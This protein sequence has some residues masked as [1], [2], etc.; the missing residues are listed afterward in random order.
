MKDLLKDAGHLLR[1]VLVFAVGFIL[2]LTVRAIAVPHSFGQYGHY[3]GD[4]LSEI[5][6]RPINFAGR[7][8]CV[9]CHQEVDDLKKTGKHAGVG[10]ESCHGALAAHAEDP[11]KLVPKLPD[12]AV[13]CVKCHEANSAKPKTFPQVVSKDHANGMACN[14]CHQPHKPAIGSG[15]T[16]QPDAKPQAKA[17]PNSVASI[18]K[19][20][21]A[22]P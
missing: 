8:A 4:S 22:K 20:P 2:F 12:T 10:C 9:M 16:P 1:I 6:A 11:E 17:A 5:A 7:D 14:T 18:P 15:Q 13:L 19:S 21:G 3:R